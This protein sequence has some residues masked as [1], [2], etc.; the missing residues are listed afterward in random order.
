MADILP[1]PGSRRYQGRGRPL[2]VQANPHS[3]RAEAFRTLRTNLQF[4]D[5]ANHPLSIVFT[6]SIPVKVRRRRRRRT[7]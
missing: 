6:S 2:I 7:C 4:V 1:A 3:P 5:A